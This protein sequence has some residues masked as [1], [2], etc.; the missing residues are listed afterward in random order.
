MKLTIGDWVA[1]PSY[2]PP[3]RP[4]LPPCSC[5]ALRQEGLSQKLGMCMA[6]SLMPAEEGGGSFQVGEEERRGEERVPGGC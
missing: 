2:S 3:P 4:S 5:L 6:L 1:V